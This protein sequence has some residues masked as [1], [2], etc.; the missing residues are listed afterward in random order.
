MLFKLALYQLM[1][2]LMR[3]CK[4]AFASNPLGLE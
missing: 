4:E 1:S 2:Q 3:L